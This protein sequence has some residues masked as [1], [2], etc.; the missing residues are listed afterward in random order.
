MHLHNGSRQWAHNLDR[1]GFAPTFE[2]LA[3]ESARLNVETATVRLYIDWYGEEP[4]T[5]LS[6]GGAASMPAYEAE[7]R[8]QVHGERLVRVEQAA[9]PFT[10]DHYSRDLRG[11]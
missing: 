4:V 3:V 8:A 5:V 1:F 11:W 2:D 7:I 10:A 6:R 9:L